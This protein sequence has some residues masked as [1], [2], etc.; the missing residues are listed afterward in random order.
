MAQRWH[1][2]CSLPWC[3]DLIG[4]EIE[5]VVRMCMSCGC[6]EANERHK[7]ADITLDDLKR[8]AQNHNLEVE[9]TAD[10]IHNSAREMKQAGRIS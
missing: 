4:D 8:A 3:A 5:E 7:P 1:D 2:P 6:G 10:N 9:Q